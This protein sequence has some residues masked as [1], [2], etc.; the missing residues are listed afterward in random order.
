MS[1][2][3]TKAASA[4]GDQKAYLGEMCSCRNAAVSAM[5]SVRSQ[6]EQADAVNR[7]NADLTDRW[8]TEMENH[9][10]FRGKYYIHKDYNVNHVVRSKRC[11]PKPCCYSNCDVQR[12]GAT[13]MDCQAA[14]KDSGYPYAEEY[15]DNGERE[16]GDYNCSDVY[17]SPGSVFCGNQYPKCSRPADKIAERTRAYEA[18]A[19]PPPVLAPV[20]PVSADIQCCSKYMSL[21]ND[22]Y[23]DAQA[24]VT[25]I[26]RLASNVSGATA[27]KEPTPQQPVTQI[28]NDTTPVTQSL[29]GTAPTT[30]GNVWRF[31][32]QQWVAA[33]LVAVVLL[34]ACVWI[35]V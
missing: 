29:D 32:Q 20:P 33:T 34:V 3:C 7:A 1:E 28:R 16:P 35:F 10:N 11:L 15:R 26:A 22:A 21:G 8:N 30:T 13:D 17:R 18:A 27:V 23:A 25:A 4:T 14:A 24:C 9:K 5:D 31:T 2:V 12:S 19:P 6:R